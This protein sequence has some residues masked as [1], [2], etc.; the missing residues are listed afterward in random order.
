MQDVGRRI[1][2]LRTARGITQEQLAE[3]ARVDARTVQRA[4]AGRHLTLLF[5]IRV[6]EILDAPMTALFE[7]PRARIPRSPGRPRTQRAAEAAPAR[8]P[9]RR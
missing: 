5:L 9:P 7:V 4:E 2:E 3:R 6:A 1:T 8:R